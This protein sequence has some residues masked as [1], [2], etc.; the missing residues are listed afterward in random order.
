MLNLA[1]ATEIAKSHNQKYDAVQEYADA[2]EFFIND[3]VERVG[4]GDCS[5]IVE[6][7][8]G[9]MLRW[10][11]YFMDGNRDINEIGEIRPLE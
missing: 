11:E 3:G 9:K 1:E 4:G 2:Y 5:V 7:E 6:K 10:G 8:S